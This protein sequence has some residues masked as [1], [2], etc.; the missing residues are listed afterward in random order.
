MLPN[1]DYY[2][3]QTHRVKGRMREHRCYHKRCTSDYIILHKCKTRKEA[4]WY[5]DVWHE[6]GFPGKKT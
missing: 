6:I 3:G 2:V 4:K 5:E 1:A